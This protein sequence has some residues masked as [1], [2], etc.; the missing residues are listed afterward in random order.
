MNALLPDVIASEPVERKFLKAAKAGELSGYDCDAQLA[1]AE[2]KGVI[3]AAEAALLRRVREAT[4]EFIS[5]DDFDAA[6][7]AAGRRSKPTL[8]SVA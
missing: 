6:D 8:R 5:V 3:S 4:F 7:L 2:K 1:D